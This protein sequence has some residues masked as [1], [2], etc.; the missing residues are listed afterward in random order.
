MQAR[1]A[2]GE[3]AEVGHRRLADQYEPGFGDPRR[4][5]RIDRLRLRRAG[6]GA[7]GRRV[8][9]GVEVLF[10][11]DRHAV[12]RRQRALSCP[13]GIAGGGRNARAI[14]FR[15]VERIE[16]RFALG[17]ARFER[18]HHIDGRHAPDVELTREVGRREPAKRIHGAQCSAV[19]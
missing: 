5:R 14:P 16:V 7:D 2:A 15:Q 8:A 12:E 13:T 18:R 10:Q 11:R 19:A 9:R 3:H 6:R 17:G 1:L 4:N